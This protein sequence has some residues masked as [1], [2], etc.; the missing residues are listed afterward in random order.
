MSSHLPRLGRRGFLLGLTALAA[1]GPAR[2]AVADVAPAAQIMDRR[3]VVILLRG[4]MDGLHAV[5]PYGDPDYAALRGELALKDPGQEG[6]VLD[7]G[8]QFGLHPKLAALHGMYAQGELLPVHAIAGP[9]R[10]RSHFDGQDLMEGGGLQRLESGWL[11]RA[12]THIPES[13]GQPARTGLALGL[14]LPLLMRGEAPV[15]MWAPPRPTRPEPD[16]YARMA[17][18]LHEDAVLGPTVL[19]GMRG[20][21][22]AVG[23]LSMGGA[24]PTNQ[25]GFTRLAAA[26]GRMLAR[27][28]GPRVAALELGGWDTH[29]GQAQRIDPVLVQ[30]D[31]G[32]AALR[33]ELGEAWSRTAVLAITEFGRTARANGNLGTDHGTGGAAFLAGGAVRGG[34]VL[35]N[36]PGLKRENL[37]EN[38]DLQP[39]RDLR[40]LAKALLR[41]HLRLSDGAV[42]AAFPGSEDVAAEG[43]LLRA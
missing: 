38:R 27:P 16:L 8:G 37:F 32:I 21:G 5:V 39:T 31:R 3:L 28:D 7:L 12:L 18:L 2:L 10:T 42:A 30:L 24:I 9:Y 35:A 15:G 41:D 34:R 33:T 43:G 14:D 17:E 1:A 40:A 36:W 22:Y 13:A 11:N 23:A 25:G 4:A 6:G 26:A 20:R 19:E 29:A